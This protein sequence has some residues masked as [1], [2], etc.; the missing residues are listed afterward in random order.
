M[1]PSLQEGVRQAGSDLGNSGTSRDNL[2]PAGAVSRA[3]DLVQYQYCK[4]R[5]PTGRA[6]KRL[7]G[8]GI[9]PFRVRAYSRE[10]RPSNAL[11]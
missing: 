11:A 6:Q 7:L 9:A 10:V 8:S 3:P 2:H 1:D 5:E 4:S